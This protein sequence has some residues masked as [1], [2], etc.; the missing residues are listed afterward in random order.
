MAGKTSDA[1]VE[2]QSRLMSPRSAALSQVHVSENDVYYF[3]VA[4]KSSALFRWTCS[5]LA[6]KPDCAVGM[7][8]LPSRARE[9]KRRDI[10]NTHGT[11]VIPHDRNRPLGFSKL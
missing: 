8:L 6:L 7:R 9:H 3:D 11:G 2:L 10:I 5:A 1:P 4:G